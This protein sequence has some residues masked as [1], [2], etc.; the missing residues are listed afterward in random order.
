MPLMLAAEVAGWLAGAAA[1]AA[2]HR[3]CLGHDARCFGVAARTAATT[4]A[5]AVVAAGG[6]TFVML[7]RGLGVQKAGGDAAADDGAAAGK[8]AK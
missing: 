7:V 8:K 1:A 2:A 4:A 6:M 3:W 5:A